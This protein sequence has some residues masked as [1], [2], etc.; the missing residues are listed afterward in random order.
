MCLFKKK[1][2]SEN[3][4]LKYRYVIETDEDKEG[5]VFT[6]EADAED[7]YYTDYIASFSFYVNIVSYKSEEETNKRYDSIMKYIYEYLENMDY[8][9]LDT[10]LIRNV[11]KKNK[12]VDAKIN[13][14]DIVNIFNDKLK[15]KIDDGRDNF[16]SDNKMIELISW[17]V[18]RKH[19]E[20]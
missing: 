3:L 5:C 8:I 4:N 7:Y 17:G 14:L 11:N 16:I 10:T 18:R 1:L 15:D 20:R 9:E 19:P 2:E 12:L 13:V 6:L